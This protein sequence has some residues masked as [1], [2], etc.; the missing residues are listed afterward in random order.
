MSLVQ[1]RKVKSNEEFYPD[2][3]TKCLS[4]SWQKCENCTYS[5]DEVDKYFCRIGSFV[6]ISNLSTL[7]YFYCGGKR[8]Y[9][10]Q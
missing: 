2:C 6:I 8:Y 5:V 3:Q 1:L 10:C 9:I 7:E 4:L